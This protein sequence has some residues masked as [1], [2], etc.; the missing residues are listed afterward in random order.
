M[1]LEKIT[2]RLLSAAVLGLS[3]A[4][5]ATPAFAADWIFADAI[6]AN[7]TLHYYDADTIQRTGNQVT[8]WEKWDHS[9]D[10]TEKIRERKLRVRYD[11]A[12]RTSTSLNTIIYF[13]DGKT[14]FFTWEAYQ[15]TADPVV[16]ESIADAKLN[17]VCTATSP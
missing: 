3:V 14:E 11:C 13:P 2:V 9:R 10:K 8:V 6:D 12:E 17:A 5:L 4:S 16:P 15:Q 7:G 1:P